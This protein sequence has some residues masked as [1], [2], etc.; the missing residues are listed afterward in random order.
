MKAL[1][2]VGFKKALKFIWFSLIVGLLHLTFIP[3]IRAMIMRLCG[4]KIGRDTI[5][6][7]ISFANFTITV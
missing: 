6:E 7:D 1:Q 4:A 3:Q 2:E 5:I